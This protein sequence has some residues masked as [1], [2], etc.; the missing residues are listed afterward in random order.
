[1]LLGDLS[2]SFYL[3]H[4]PVLVI[5][6]SRLE[7]AG[8]LV[9]SG[10]VAAALLASWVSYRFIESPVRQ[11]PPLARSATLSLG[12]GIVL[13]SLAASVA[14][15][16][17]HLASSPTVVVGANDKKVDLGAALLDPTDGQRR[18]SSYLACTAVEYEVVDLPS[19]D[20]GDLD[21]D[22]TAVL[23]GDSHMGS[24]ANA[25]VPAASAAG[26]HLK[27][28]TKAACTIADVTVYDEMRKARNT[29]CDAYRRTIFKRTVAEKPALVVLASSRNDRKRVYDR[30][31]GKRLTATQ[32]RPRIIAG[33]KSTIDYFTS[34]DIPVKV[35][36][37]WPASPVN[38]QDCLAK[39][40]DVSACTFKPP[41][42]PNPE[43]LATRELH[44]P[45]IDVD[46]EFCTDTTC[47]PV[48]AKW[49]VFSD[50]SHLTRRYA[51]H[52]APLI[53][54]KVLDPSH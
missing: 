47:T 22:H 43:T 33:W 37:D 2:Y 12:L 34:R 35:V 8:W 5:G 24:L 16:S 52:L 10:L 1:V 19:C 45:L 9:R 7:P 50:R 15:A 48:V 3:C 30:A 31:T 13:V 44:V 20:F 40:K 29:K 39:T 53:R 21:A 42:L 4:F 11:L 49:L 32:S 18:D 14:I 26:W 25:F 36:Q 28:W 46:D 54:R 38:P 27:I 41:A 17:P 6:L 23:L 51:E